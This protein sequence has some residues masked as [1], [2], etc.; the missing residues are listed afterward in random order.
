MMLSI[1]VRLWSWRQYV[2]MVWIFFLYTIWVCEYTTANTKCYDVRYNTN[3]MYDYTVFITD[4]DH[5]HIGIC[6]RGNVTAWCFD[7]L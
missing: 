1:V 4:V 6:I 2:S 7:V 5:A 3:Q